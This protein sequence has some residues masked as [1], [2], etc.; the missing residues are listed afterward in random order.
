M[1]SIFILLVSML[2][3]SCGGGG[4][5]DDG[6]TP[7]RVQPATITVRGGTAPICATGQGPEIFVFGGVPPYTVRNTVPRSLSLDKTVVGQ[8]GES[9]ALTFLG[10]CLENVAVIFVDKRGLEVVV[11]VTNSPAN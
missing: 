7:L 2:L 5:V 10:G 4:S 6:T 3:L 1:K 8:S 11:S 9:T